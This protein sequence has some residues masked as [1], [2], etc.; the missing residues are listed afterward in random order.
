MFFYFSLLFFCWFSI[1]DG[2]AGV[3]NKYTIALHP[4]HLETISFVTLL[5][6]VVSAG[7]V[8][9]LSGFKYTKPYAIALSVLYFLFLLL[10]IL[11]AANVRNW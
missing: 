3:N 4:D 6:S 5:V 8:V 11:A 2:A 7:I 10:G 1:L 9:P